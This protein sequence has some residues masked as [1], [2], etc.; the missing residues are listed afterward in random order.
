MKRPRHRIAGGGHAP[1][2]PPDHRRVPRDRST[3]ADW[4]DWVPEKE[5]V[6]GPEPKRGITQFSTMLTCR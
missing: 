6:V 3:K 1:A 5:L 2:A 4:F